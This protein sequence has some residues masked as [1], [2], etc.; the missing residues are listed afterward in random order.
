M[1]DNLSTC[2][3]PNAPALSTTPPR[4]QHFAA[5]AKADGHS[6]YPALFDHQPLNQGPGSDR[7]I[8]L[9]GQ[10]GARRR[11]AFTALLRHLIKPE[12]VLRRAIEVGVVGQLQGLGAADKF[13]AGGVGPALVHHVE[14]ALAA[15]P[16]ITAALVVLG[17]FEI[18]QHIG[19]GPAAAAQ[20]GPLI[21]IE[22]VAADI[23]HRVDRR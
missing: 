6:G 19:V 21:V 9:R 18:G 17:A 16:G 20:F 5:L 13:A 12:A 22:M 8:G 11:P 23:D 10:V 3:L 15:V 1:P 14:R 7:Q 4:A 2:G